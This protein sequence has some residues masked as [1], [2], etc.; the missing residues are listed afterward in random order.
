MKKIS[1]LALVVSL[2][3]PL[4]LAHATEVTQLYTNNL[5]A[6]ASSTDDATGMSTQVFV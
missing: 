6:I 3:L 4:S 2:L 1:G 5:F